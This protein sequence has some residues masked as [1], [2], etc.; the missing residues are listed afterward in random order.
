MPEESSKPVRRMRISPGYINQCLASLKAGMTM[1][2]IDSI[3]KNSLGPRIYVATVAGKVVLGGR[4]RR[5]DSHTII[6]PIDLVARYTWDSKPPFPVRQLPL[7]AQPTKPST[8][9]PVYQATLH[10][11]TPDVE[12]KLREILGS[13]LKEAT[14]SI[15]SSINALH[16]K[17]QYL[18][19][20]FSN[21]ERELGV[22]PVKHQ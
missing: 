4:S 6:K 1:N 2:P 5:S 3:K 21:L 15:C 16:V 8:P 17:L 11:I 12:A 13:E 14:L 10:A 7:P 9:Q 22:V 19:D 18:S 20:H